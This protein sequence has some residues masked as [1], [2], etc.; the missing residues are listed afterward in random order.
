[1]MV[2]GKK[3]K[4]KRK[5]KQKGHMSVSLCCLCSAS[6]CL[7]LSLLLISYNVLG[8][9]RRLRDTKRKRRE[10]VRDLYIDHLSEASSDSVSIMNGAYK[11]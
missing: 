4:K 7:S 5:E 3:R 1:M 8:L 6:G 10:A 2:G 11:L 9:K